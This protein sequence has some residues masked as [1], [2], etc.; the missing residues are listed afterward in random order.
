MFNVL[1]CSSF[2]VAYNGDHPD[3]EIAGSL[4]GDGMTQDEEFRRRI[5]IEEEERKLK[6]TLEYQRQIEYE[7]KQKHLA[8]QHEKSPCTHQEKVDDRLLMD[9]YLECGP[10]VLGVQKQSKPYLQVFGCDLIFLCLVFELHFPW[11]TR[12]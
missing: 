12:L 2:P 11:T 4:T 1:Y 8:E 6:E 9:V 10:V 5:E 7:A 3:S